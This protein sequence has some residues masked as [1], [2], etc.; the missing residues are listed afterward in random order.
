MTKIG[1]FCIIIIPF[2]YEIPKKMILYMYTYLTNH[3]HT[4]VNHFFT[5]GNSLVDDR[6]LILPI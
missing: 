3:D 6:L 1:K 4:K 2:I 5:L